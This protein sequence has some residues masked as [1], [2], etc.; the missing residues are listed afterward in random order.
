MFPTMVIFLA[1][2]IIDISRPPQK[3]P[4]VLP[5]ESPIFRF[6]N[7]R[8][9]R[10]IHRVS[11]PVSA[12]SII[13]KVI[14]RGRIW[15]RCV[16]SVNQRWH[17]KPALYYVCLRSISLAGLAQP[18]RALHLGARWAGA[19]GRNCA[20]GRL[21]MTLPRVDDDKHDPRPFLQ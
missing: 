4:T 9:P 5:V 14:C 17:G 6:G 7:P 10:R 8:S 13:V 3:R 15:I 20:A 1:F 19:A 12:E 18:A 11:T 2:F 21:G 16:C